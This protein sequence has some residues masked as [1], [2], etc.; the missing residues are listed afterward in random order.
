MAEGCQPTRN[1]QFTAMKSSTE[2]NGDSMP[3][4]QIAASPNVPAN[5]CPTSIPTDPQPHLQE[6]RYCRLPAESRC[7]QCSGGPSP[8]CRE[9]ETLQCPIVRAGIAFV[10]KSWN[11]TTWAVQIAVGLALMIWGSETTIRILL[12]LVAI[13]ILHLKSHYGQRQEIRSLAAS[14]QRSEQLLRQI[15]C[16]LAGQAATKLPE[17]TTNQLELFSH[18]CRSERTD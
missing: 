10:Q 18:H 5:R 3:I 12:V 2:P 17:K 14:Q 13:A 16:H 7:P 6:M 4:N 15:Q 9:W 1:G 8:E 11:F